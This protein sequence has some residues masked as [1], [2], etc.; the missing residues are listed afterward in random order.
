MTIDPSLIARLAHRAAPLAASMNP[1]ERQAAEAIARRAAM[2]GPTIRVEGTTGVV[3]KERTEL[4]GDIS[5][6][7]IARSATALPFMTRATNSWVS[8]AHIAAGD[9]VNLTLLNY[10]CYFI[11]LYIGRPGMY[12]QIA[13]RRGA[14]GTAGE[15][16]NMAIWRA[17]PVSLDPIEPLSST[18]SQTDAS[19]GAAGAASVSPVLTTPAEITFPQWIYVAMAFSGN[20]A[21]YG[22]TNPTGSLIHFGQTVT[23]NFDQLT[24]ITFSPITAA[25]KTLSVAGG[26][27]TNTMV[28][29]IGVRRTA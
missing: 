22:V 20:F 28:P 15:S 29:L 14:A 7:S 21:A 27:G 9:R 3:P 24:P 25:S 13:I 5:L 11:P 16:Y 8:S 19:A 10:L 12:G 23:N 4:S 17:D 2:G 1:P 18:W 6:E 26:L